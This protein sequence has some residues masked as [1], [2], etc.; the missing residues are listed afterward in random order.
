M[1]LLTL[2]S[3]IGQQDYL[4]GALKGQL[5]QINP[6][7]TLIDISHTLSPFNYPQAAYVCRNAINNFPPFTFHLL[8]VNLFEKSQSNCCWPTTRN[9]I[10]F[11]PTMAC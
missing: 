2:T 5:L 7:F 11:V 8:L 3:D 10:F 1:A 9:N 4:V 6:A